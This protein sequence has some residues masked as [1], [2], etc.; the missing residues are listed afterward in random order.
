MWEE[1][2]LVE[3]QALLLDVSSDHCIWSPILMLGIPREAYITSLPGRIFTRR[4][5]FQILFGNDIFL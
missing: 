2:L 3:C 1:E 5:L 4:Y